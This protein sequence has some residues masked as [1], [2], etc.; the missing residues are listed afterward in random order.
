MRLLLLAGLVLSGSLW[1]R[2]AEPAEAAQ[3]CVKP[4]QVSRL[5]DGEPRPK[6]FRVLKGHG[7]LTAYSTYWE[8]R[9]YLRC[10]GGQY[11]VLL[12]RER[13]FRLACESGPSGRRC[14]F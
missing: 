8:N 11:N 4:T 13:G 10:G 5:Y 7:T 2:T 1:V 12:V 9:R 14:W 3:P 6:V